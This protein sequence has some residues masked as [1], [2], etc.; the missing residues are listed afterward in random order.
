MHDYTN[1]WTFLIEI[2]IIVAAMIIFLRVKETIGLVVELFRRD[3]KLRL[4][5][6]RIGVCVLGAAVI[7]IVGSMRF[8]IDNRMLYKVKQLKQYIM[9]MTF[10]S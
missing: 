2:V 8:S 5:V 9:R 6:L 1:H 4:A 7:V 10:S 3:D